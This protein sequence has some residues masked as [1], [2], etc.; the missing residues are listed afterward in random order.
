MWKSER[1]YARMREW[2]GQCVCVCVWEMEK[3]IEYDIKKER[4]DKDIHWDIWIKSRVRMWQKI[5][6]K[7]TVAQKTSALFHNTKRVRYFHRFCFVLLCWDCNFCV[8]TMRL[9]GCPYEAPK[10]CN[11]HY[12]LNSQMVVTSSKFWNF[13]T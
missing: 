1:D 10:K 11:S 6:L 9:L 5:H 3:E 12:H 2:D 7:T 4:E 13:L 8:I